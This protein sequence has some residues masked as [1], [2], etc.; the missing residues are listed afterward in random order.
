MKVV[1]YS[2]RSLGLRVHVLHLQIEELFFEIN[3][4]TQSRN[5]VHKAGDGLAFACGLRTTCS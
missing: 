3:Q 4:V 5:E 2:V 1:N